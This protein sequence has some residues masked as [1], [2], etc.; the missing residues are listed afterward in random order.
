[1]VMS[2]AFGESLTSTGASVNL[3]YS[4]EARGGVYPGTD[5]VGELVELRD[6]P[7]HVCGEEYEVADDEG[8]CRT[9]EEASAV[10]VDEGHSDLE[11]CLGRGCVLGL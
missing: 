6:D 7:L 1:M 3:V 2:L 11:D 5:D 9:K 4:F 8:G 10:Y